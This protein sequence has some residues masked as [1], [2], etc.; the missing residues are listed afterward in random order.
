M[1][2]AKTLEAKMKRTRRNSNRGFTMVLGFMIGFGPAGGA[3]WRPKSLYDSLGSGA[4]WFLD[5]PLFRVGNIEVTPIFLIKC[6][7]FL[8]ALSLLTKLS[9]R[10][11]AKRILA[12]TK[13]ERGHQY[14]IVRTFGYF[15]FLLGLIVGLNSTGLNL[16]SLLVVGGALGVGVG[17]GLQNVVANFVAGLVILFEQPI[18]L[19]DTVEVGGTTGEVVKIGARGTW[20]RTNDNEVI[21]VPNS[22]FVNNRVTNWTAN[23]RT[24]R[25]SIPVGVSYDS[26]LKKVR[27]LLEEIAR[28]HPESL[29]D[30]APTAVV[31]TFGDSSVNFMLRV[32]SASAL[33]HAG[34]F[35]SDLMMEI[36]RVFREEKIEM[37]NPQRD[38]HVR[39]VDTP[40]VI[41][42]PGAAGMRKTKEF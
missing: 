31:R 18:K 10:F 32:S 20:V 15:V 1:L 38:I 11:L 25:F 21:I 34:V 4:R 3:E 27:R 22:E 42:R 24:I 9:K 40:L 28:K 29:A 19:G 36:A 37:P 35:Q 16:S 41:T 5:W 8:A 39:S 12:R 17:F 2:E 7:V 33:E 14:A 13:I 30:P 6:A 23:D 26:D